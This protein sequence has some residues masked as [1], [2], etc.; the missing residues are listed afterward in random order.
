MTTT[1]MEAWGASARG[2]VGERRLNGGAVRPASTR[3][4]APERAASNVHRWIILSQDVP[5][6]RDAK[7]F[8]IALGFRCPPERENRERRDRTYRPGE[9]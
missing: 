6:R 2:Y 7:T 8:A 9:R 4:R 1:M 3:R 5:D